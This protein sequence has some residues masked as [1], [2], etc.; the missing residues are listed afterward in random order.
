MSMDHVYLTKVTWATAHESQGA[1]QPDTTMAVK[2]RSSCR[3][4]AAGLP[5][6]AEFL[7]QVVMVKLSQTANLLFIE[8]ANSSGAV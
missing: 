4:A 2:N 3:N 6:Q 8:A 5:A 7:E 1:R